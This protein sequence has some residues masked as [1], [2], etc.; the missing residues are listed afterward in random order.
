MSKNTFIQVGD[1]I[2]NPSYI[3][4]IEFKNDECALTIRRTSNS[5][6]Q[7]WDTE[8]RI[9]DKQ[10]CQ[11][12]IDPIRIHQMSIRQLMPTG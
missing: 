2:V 10:Q 1:K 3:K 5:S 9:E 6:Y 7:I 4:Y 8:I 12:L 11:R